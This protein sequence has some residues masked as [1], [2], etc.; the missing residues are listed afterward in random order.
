MVATPG[1]AALGRRLEVGLAARRGRGRGRRVPARHG[2]DD[3][4]RLAG[5]GR[6]RGG[7]E[8][9]APDDD[10]GVLVLGYGSA[11]RGIIGELRG[12]G[13]QH[14]VV[15]LSPDGAAEAEAD[16]VQVVVGDYA[17]Q[18]VLTHVGAERA[19]AVVLGDDDPERTFRVTLLV[20]ELNPT[21]TIIVRPTEDADVAELA[22]AGA[23]HVVTPERASHIGLAIAVRDVL[24]P[25]AGPVPLSTVVRFEPDP[26]SPCPHLEEIRPVQPSAYGCEDC[27]RIGSTWVHL[28]ICL[29]CGHVGCCDSSPH[30][31]AR[32]HSGAEGHPIMA[33]FE[34][35]EHW[36]HCFFDDTDIGPRVDAPS[37][38]EVAEELGL[39]PDPEPALAD[40]EPG[41]DGEGDGNGDGDDGRAEGA[42]QVR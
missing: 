14:T 10:R 38:R 11:A 42:P 4:H 20:R 34:P 37:S 31:H 18:A 3:T 1:V 2:R 25:H 33:S 32:A 23:D 17:K 26:S 22:A 5:D 39:R 16:G 21:A 12:L 29:T 8:G 41:D 36:A 15:T 28:R 27:L 40:A 30:R 24:A 7:G 13:V 35:G 9:G 19:R 6:G